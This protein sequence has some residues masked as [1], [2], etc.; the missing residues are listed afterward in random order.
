MM[1]PYPIP[2]SS[3]AVRPESPPAEAND[4]EADGG[5]DTPPDDSSVSSGDGPTAAKR[6]RKPDG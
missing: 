6:K 3:L 2:F 1:K 4:A 5:S